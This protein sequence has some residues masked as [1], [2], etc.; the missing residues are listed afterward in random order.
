MFQPVGNVARRNWKVKKVKKV[1]PQ[2]GITRG[3][4]NGVGKPGL[5]LSGCVTAKTIAFPNAIWERENKRRFNRGLLGLLG[6]AE[7]KTMP[8]PRTLQYV[9]YA[10]VPVDINDNGVRIER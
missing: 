7:R 1:I 10:L 5:A 4:R 2:S 6:S 9:S 8:Q 3:E